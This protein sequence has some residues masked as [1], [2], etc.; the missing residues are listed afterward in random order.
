[1]LT[2]NCTSKA[3][4]SAPADPGGSVVPQPE[5]TRRRFLKLMIGAL[6]TLVTIALAVPFIGTIIG[7]SF[8][9]KKVKWVKVAHM[10]SLVLDQP[11]NLKFPYKIED[12]YI[13]ET[14]THSVWVIKHSSSELTVFSPI[15]PH[16]GCHY[17]WHP[18]Q[19]EFICPCHGSV[20]SIDGKVLGGPAPRSLDMLPMK[21]EG[22]ELFIEWETFRV[23][24]PQKIAI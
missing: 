10:N 9:T 2:C 6:S 23:G 20:F 8:R 1:M 11:A 7:P 4:V 24:V 15:C 5:T 13:R 14:V 21:I 18:E 12:A 19:K 22:E 16:L 3:D 17:D